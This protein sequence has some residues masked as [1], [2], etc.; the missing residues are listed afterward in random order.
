MIKKFIKLGNSM[1]SNQN[2]FWDWVEEEAKRLNIDV[3][4]FIEEFLV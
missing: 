3:L 4:Y 2:D 1:N